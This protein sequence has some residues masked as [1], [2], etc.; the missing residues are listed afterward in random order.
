MS[1]CGSLCRFSPSLNFVGLDI[2]ETRCRACRSSLATARPPLRG[3]IGAWGKLKVRGVLGVENIEGLDEIVL[4]SVVRG[5]LGPG[6]GTDGGGVR[7][8]KPKL[9]QGAVSAGTAVTIEH[10]H[11][12]KD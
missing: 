2:V 12:S 6:F 9:L 7:R 4:F 5:V 11:V 8:S 10:A 1:S 3:E